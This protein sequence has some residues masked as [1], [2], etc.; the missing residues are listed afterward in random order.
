MYMAAWRNF[1]KALKNVKYIT[2]QDTPSISVNNLSLKIWYKYNV[3]QQCWNNY[4]HY[5]YVWD[6]FY[7]QYYLPKQKLSMNK[8]ICFFLLLYM[9]QL[10]LIFRN[11]LFP[12]WKRN[13]IKT[14]FRPESSNKLEM[15]STNLC[16]I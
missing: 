9:S 15:S 5:I 10:N 16:F 13:C 6:Y 11:F 12:F 7:V 4:K 1:W 2:S 14:K 8:R 3:L